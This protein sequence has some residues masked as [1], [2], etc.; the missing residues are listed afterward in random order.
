MIY[1]YGLHDPDGKLRYI[2]QTNNPEFRLR[3][4]WLYRDVPR[5]WWLPV[6]MWLR[7][8]RKRPEMRII[9]TVS[10]KY[11][12]AVEVEYIL[13]AREDYPGQMLNVLPY[14]GRD[15]PEWAAWDEMERL[16]NSGFIPRERLSFRERWDD[17]E[18][19]E[20][21]MARMKAY[22]NEPGSREAQGDRLRAQWDDPEF[23][24]R[25]TEQVR[26]WAR[27]GGA[28]AG[29][30]A[31]SEKPVFRAEKSKWMKSMRDDPD[32]EARRQ[33]SLQ[34]PECRAQMS[35]S[36]KARWDDPDLRAQ[37]G[38]IQKARW[39]DP[40]KRAEII[41]A[42]R[43]GRYGGAPD[44]PCRECGSEPLSFDLSCASCRKRRRHPDVARLIKIPADMPADVLRKHMRLR[45]PGYAATSA[46]HAEAHERTSV[47]KQDHRHVRA[48][49]M[50]TSPAN[51]QKRLYAVAGRTQPGGSNAAGQSG[52]V[53][54]RVG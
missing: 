25:R 32:I 22:W 6:C 53:R 37:W 50:A 35:R 34:A 45:H 42:Q 47:S 44:E 52:S 17:P 33:A 48:R 18:Y 2:G 4:H 54:A 29:G 23:R 3:N 24:E 51:G 20:A 21:W 7:T 36:Q 41:A 15:A 31:V 40:V 1:I 16:D 27:N 5:T 30:R 13:N 43:N 28:S 8:L 14:P 9:E 38:E 49:A 19:R 10:R 11:A 39:D 12:N 26:Q 46:A